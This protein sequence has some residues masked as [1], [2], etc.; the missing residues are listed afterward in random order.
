VGLNG[1]NG[2]KHRYQT[3]RDEECELPYCRIYREG[4]ADGY[5]DGHGAGYGA[6]KA[7]GYAEGYSD[8]AAA[9]AG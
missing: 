4:Y 3:C 9:A 8:G 1:G 7:D 2:D 6:G 5:E